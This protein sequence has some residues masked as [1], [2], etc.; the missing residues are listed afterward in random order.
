VYSSSRI[1]IGRPVTLGQ[2][3]AHL[4]ASQ[5]GPRITFVQE[6][7]VKFLTAT[8]T[9]FTTA[10]LAHC[11]W[12][13][14]SPDVLRDVLQNLIPHVDRICLAEYALTATDP[15][16]VVHLLA[17]LTQ[18][19]LECRKQVTVS[20]IRTVLSPAAI[21]DHAKDVGLVQEGEQTFV[22]NE[23]MLDGFWEVSAV[24]AQ[25]FLD[26]VHQEVK[27]EREKAVVIALRDSVKASKAALQASGKKVRTMDVW[28]TTFK[29]GSE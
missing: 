27:N 2:A 1:S 9:K 17:A 12:Y 10:I 23:G 29:P 14:A 3:Q 24:L 20:N 8:K 21:H 4:K 25:K 26:S 22:P 16:S 28:V 13:F 5:L 18:A 19:S 7:P 11:I 6:D 15:C